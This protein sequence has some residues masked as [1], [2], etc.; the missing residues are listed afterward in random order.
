MPKNSSKTNIVK[1][2]SIFC[3]SLYRVKCFKPLFLVIFILRIRLHQ[4][5]GTAYFKHLHCLV[6]HL[7]LDNAPYILYGVKAKASFLTNQEQNH[8]GH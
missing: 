5:F 1:K 4:K 3:H 6:S 2:K 8:H 7:L